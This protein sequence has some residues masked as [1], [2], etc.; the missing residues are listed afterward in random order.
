MAVR[1]SV[2]NNSKKKKGYSK[3]IGSYGW[4]TAGDRYFKLTAVVSKKTRVYESPQSAI[5][6]GWFIVTLG[7]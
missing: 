1:G 7:K 4:N 6:D 3:S 2:W 5:E